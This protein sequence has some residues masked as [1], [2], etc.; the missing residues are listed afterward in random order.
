M[1]I[2]EGYMPFMGHQTYYRIVGECKDGKKPILLIHGGPGSTHNYF[3]VLD[4][5]AESGRAVISYDQIGCGNSYLDGCPELWT[6]KTWTEELIAL[7]KHLGL[8][9]VHLLGQSWGGMLILSYLTDV[10]HEGVRSAI[11]SST[12]PSASVWAREQHRMIKYMDQ[13]EQDA[14][15]R[16]E[17]TGNFDDPEYLAANDHFME[18][19]CAPK[20]TEDSP[21]CL[22]RPKKAGSESYLHGWGPNEYVP[23]GD[24]HDFEY[25]ERCPEIKEPTLVIS[26]TDDLC[27]PLLAKAMYD[28]LPESEWV[29]F[30]GCR[31]VP[32]IEDNEHYCEVLTKWLDKIDERYC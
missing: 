30:E 6:L 4:S 18:L 16:A 22:R 1:K 27:T 25:I 31:H 28:N 8:D 2:E 13:A 26:G 3:E 12:N 11:L 23:T 20:V 10:E 29:L 7:R 9:E 14:I 5:I 24:L 21:E 19:H 17:A 32:F 15:A